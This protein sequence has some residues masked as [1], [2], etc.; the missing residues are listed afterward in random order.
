MR[1]ALTWMV[2]AGE[3]V[4]GLRLAVALGR[5]WHIGG[6]LGE[7]QRWLQDLLA[8]AEG[9]PAT[10]QAKALRLLGDGAYD[11]GDLPAARDF[12]ARSLATARAADDA[13]AIAEALLGVAAIA[14][15]LDGDLVASAAHLTHSLELREAAGDRWGAALMRINLAE[16]A[17][18]RGDIDAG[19]QLIES[20]LRAW[21]ALGYR[22]GIGRAL[23]MLAQLDEQRGDVAAASARYDECYHAWGEVGYRAGIAEAA[24]SLGWLA[25]AAGDLASAAPL[26]AESLS[27]WR[28]IGQQ[29][30]VAAALEGCAAIAVAKGCPETGLRL[31]L[32]A[33]ELREAIGAAPSP[34]E[35]ARAN[36]WLGDA[37]QALGQEATVAIAAAA[38]RCL[39][40]EALDVA[41]AILQAG[42]EPAAAQATDAPAAREL[43]PREREVLHLLSRHHTDREIADALSI[44]PRTTMH[45][46]SHIL[47]KLGVASRRDAAAWAVRH[48]LH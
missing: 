33:E 26:F 2:A 39:V 16:I 42:P 37:K 38:K 14:A 10:L 34:L 19:R 18:G 48:G 21:R 23:F 20:G 6:F 13:Q 47:A 9:A 17:L 45:H 4:I 41:F 46:V 5:Y 44:S 29:K 3:G 27:L 31:V 36:P 15:D 7:R 30:G 28:E 8:L 1:A 12:Y 24:I 40:D 22:Q 25:L 32:A 43:T 35:R 11:T